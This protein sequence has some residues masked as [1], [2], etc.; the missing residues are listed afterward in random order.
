[1]I[2]L[3][4]NYLAF[5]EGKMELKDKIGI[6]DGFPKEGISFKDVSP[7]FADG[8]YLKYTLDKMSEIAGNFHPSIVLG[9]EARGFL[10]GP[11]IAYRLGIGFV[12]ARKKGKLPGDLFS[13]SYGLEYGC[14]ELFI[15]KGLIKEGD[16]V[17]IVDDLM[18]TG[19]TASALVKLVKELKATP[20][21]VET[22]IELTD[23]H[24]QDD[25]KDVPFE[26]IIK[27]PR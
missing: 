3:K 27:Y 24:G 26:S 20:V 10:F 14:D 25:F 2:N 9:P 19:G 22:L 12:M 23:F 7:L 4:Y 11:A 5:L 18:A 6:T 17:L 16:R 1:M 21:L 13:V 8:R 15:E